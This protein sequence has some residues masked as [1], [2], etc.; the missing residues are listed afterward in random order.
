MPAYFVAS[1][2]PPF[3]LRNEE[4]VLKKI[5]KINILILIEDH[6]TILFNKLISPSVN[7]FYPFSYKEFSEVLIVLIVAYHKAL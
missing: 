1:F 3:L 6:P 2:Y 4:V 5:K 7:Y